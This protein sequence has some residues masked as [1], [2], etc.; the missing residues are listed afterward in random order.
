[1]TDQAANAKRSIAT[2]TL[3]KLDITNSFTNSFIYIFDDDLLFKFEEDVRFEQTTV[4]LQCFNC[5]YNEYSSIQWNT[6]T[7]CRLL[8]FTT[9]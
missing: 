2:V 9:Y 3:W 7:W 8:N 1:L 6:A 5:K 4:F